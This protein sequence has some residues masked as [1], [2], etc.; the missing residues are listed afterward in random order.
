MAARESFNQLLN[1]V[2]ASTAAIAVEE[3]QSADWEF[4]ATAFSLLALA[5]SRLPEHKRDHWLT[6]IEDGELRG[7][8]HKYPIDALGNLN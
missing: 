4:F 2:V 7:T 6:K 3:D 5:I 8:V 1:D